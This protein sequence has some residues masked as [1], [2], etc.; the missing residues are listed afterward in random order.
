MTDIEEAKLAAE[1]TDALDGLILHS[2]RG[3][4]DRFDPPPEGLTER[5]KF[6]TTVQ[7]LEAEVAELLRV[8][9]DLAGARA[10]SSAVETITFTSRHLTVMVSIGDVGPETV[11]VDGWV[12]GG[13]VR[14]ELRTNGTTRETVADAEGRFVFDG[15]R[16]GTAQ[17]VLHRVLPDGGEEPPV[18]TPA[19]VL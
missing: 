18:V 14:I 11:R 8:P 4:F 9:A 10:E 13:G 6:A 2:L 1:P 19:V 3:A 7:A 17:F 12:T 15:V 16:R 5:I